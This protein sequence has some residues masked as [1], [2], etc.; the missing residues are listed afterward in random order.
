VTDVDENAA[1]R[2]D[3]TTEDSQR[4]LRLVTA[5]VLPSWLTLSNVSINNGRARLSG[6]PTQAHIG[7][8]AV[9]L[10]VRNLRTDSIAVQNF[11]VIVANVNDA[12]VITGQT[13]NPIPLERGTPLTV[14]LAHL[15][16]TDPDNAYPSD[17][18]LTVLNGSNYTREG[19]TITPA[20]N[21]V[22]ALS[23][24]VR[25]NDGA[26]NSGNF[27]LAVS[28]RQTIGAILS[29][30]VEATPSPALVNTAIEWRFT[31]ANTGQQSANAEIFAEVAGNPFNFTD[32]ASCT[33][34]P[35]ADGQNVRCSAATVAAGSSTTVALRGS[36]TQHGD[37]FV[38][39]RAQQTGVATGTAPE[40]VDT[41]LHVATTLGGGEAQRLPGPD[42]AGVA[43]GDVDGDGFAD[44]A[45]ARATGG[46]PVELYLNVIDGDI[47]PRRLA[48]TP[49]AIGTSGGASN[50]ALA[51]LDQDPN[52]DLITTSNT[53]GANIVYRNT[54]AGT[55]VVATTLPG[56]ASHAI[57]AADFD[58]DG[59]V[60]IAF[61][62]SGAN[63]VHLNRGASG[64]SRV[65]DLGTDDSRGVVANDFDLDGLPDLVFANANGPS[66]FYKNLGAGS[67]APGVVVDSL[68]ARTVAAGDF[69]GDGRPDLVF[70]VHS[71]A[72]GPPSNPVY[73]NDPGPGGAQFVLIKRLGAAPTAKVLAADVDGDGAA[74][75][76]AFNATG[77]HQVYRGDGVGGFTLHP[78][79]FRWPGTISA[80]LVRI[81]VDSA[82][83]L[84]VAGATS[85]ATFLNDGRGGFG[86]GDTIPPIIQLTG[87]PSVTVTFG[88]TYNDPGA[89]AMDDVDGSVTARITVTNPVDTSILG[90]YTVTYQVSD[91]AGNAAQATRAVRVTAREGV[92]GGGGGATHPFVAVVLAIAFVCRL[93]QRRHC[94]TSRAAAS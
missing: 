25:V 31:I 40:S 24:P 48:T 85:S 74:D 55:F 38:R 14:T 32:L 8:H 81:G 87:E 41:T 36:A 39:A 58:G 12:P 3:I 2:Y 69:N 1:Y 79:Q 88:E 5:P 45:L 28:V 86:L 62:N 19:N 7:T 71:N 29:L 34:T 50:L 47:G 16:V 37:V 13:P 26:S 83:D 77:T 49:L 51:S 68:G 33:S 90:P 64:F 67:F 46:A 70:G 56:G 23:V 4:G 52:L 63:T 60:D 35:L 89:S 91:N 43:A 72:A 66:R 84:A 6:R 17:F 44:I 30:S 57:A 92:G 82:P 42:H 27:N 15:L 93:R 75:A 9:S 61:A 54:G 65:A 59:A 53:G 18:S 78:V 76:I 80:V 21:F 11:S 22:G 10:Q 94:A 73:R 20:A